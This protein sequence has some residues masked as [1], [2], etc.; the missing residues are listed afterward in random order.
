MHTAL[1]MRE[2][3]SVQHGVKELQVSPR[4]AEIQKTLATGRNDQIL[5]R[6][7]Q[8]IRPE[9]GDSRIVANE[10]RDMLGQ[11]RNAPRHFA[12]RGGKDGTK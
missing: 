5:L 9:L 7:T 3:C 11:V 8:D 10:M 4:V 1:G 2:G 12:G 6:A